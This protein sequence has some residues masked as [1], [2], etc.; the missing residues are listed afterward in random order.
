MNHKGYQIIEVV[1]QRGCVR[2]K[3]P[4]VAVI[5]I[6]KGKDKIREFQFSTQEAKEKAIID[7]KKHIDELLD[8]TVR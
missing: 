7:A 8:Q 1:K 4:R 6:L 5:R 2:C 3:K